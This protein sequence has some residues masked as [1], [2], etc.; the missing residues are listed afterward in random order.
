MKKAFCATIV[1]VFLLIFSG[2]VQ[3]DISAAHWIDTWTPAEDGLDGPIHF[4]PGN[5]GADYYT[6]V[7][8]ISDHGF[9]VGD[10]KVYRYDLSIGLRDDDDRP[11]ELAW[12]N[13]PGWWTDELVEMGYDDIKLG[14]SL[15]GLF[16]LNSTGQLEVTIEVDERGFLSGRFG[17][18]CHRH[19]HRAHSRHR[20]AAGQRA[21]RGGRSAQ[22][23][24]QCG[25]A[26]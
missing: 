7:L 18:L 1:L 8:D 23:Q 20:A 4:G 21:D 26:P 15:A 2:P 3:A 16:A 10:D 22:T 14:F 24:G 19:Q 9:D 25:L 6:Y 11:I 12:I 5:S 17:D 13:L